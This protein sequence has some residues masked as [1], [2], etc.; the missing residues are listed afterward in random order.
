[1]RNEPIPNALQRSLSSVCAAG[2][3]PAGTLFGTAELRVA[4]G[5]DSMLAGL[6]TRCS[7]AAAIATSSVNG[8]YGIVGAAA[9]IAALRLS[10][11]AVT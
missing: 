3:K 11:A 5:R 1:M 9:R 7:D 2:S 4:H 6:G 8:D 10:S